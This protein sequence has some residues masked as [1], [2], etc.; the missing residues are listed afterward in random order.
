MFIFLFSIVP[1]RFPAYVGLKLFKI[2]MK[3]EEISSENLKIVRRR[4]K[5]FSFQL[6]GI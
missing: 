5:N 1:K 2:S 4:M 3:L 6:I